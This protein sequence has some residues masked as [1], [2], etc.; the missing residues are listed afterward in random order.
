MEN[1]EFKDMEQFLTKPPVL[2]LNVTEGQMDR[3]KIDMINEYLD[4]FGQVARRQYL[5]SVYTREIKEKLRDYLYLTEIKMEEVKFE[6]PSKSMNWTFAEGTIL[7]HYLYYSHN[8]NQ[9]MYISNQFT[10]GRIKEQL[11]NLVLTFAKFPKLPSVSLFILQIWDIIGFEDLSGQAISNPVLLENSGTPAEVQTLTDA[12]CDLTGGSFA[13]GSYFKNKTVYGIQ[14]GFT[15]NRGNP[16]LVYEFFCD[17]A[18]LDTADSLNKKEGTST[19]SFIVHMDIE[20]GIIRKGFL[21]EYIYASQWS[22]R[23]KGKMIPSNVRRRISIE[24]M[25]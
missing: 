18:K 22:N 3:Y 13:S 16:C 6:S 10:G 23:S 12:R 15:L 17:G 14:H 8:M 9:F 1:F 7:P 24:R 2:T 21:T 11:S 25:D 20:T 19:Y 5:K 4:P